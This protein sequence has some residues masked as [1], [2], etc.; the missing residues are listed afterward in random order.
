MYSSF[1]IRP[2]LLFLILTVTLFLDGCAETTHTRD[3]QPAQNEDNSWEDKEKRASLY[4]YIL[5]SRA[6]MIRQGK[7]FLVKDKN[8]EAVGKFKEYFEHLDLVGR[9]GHHE[10]GNDFCEVGIKLSPSSETMADCV[11]AND[12]NNRFFYQMANI[13]MAQAKFKLKKYQE[14]IPFAKAAFS[15]IK[16]TNRSLLRA[17]TA[18]FVLGKSCVMLEKKSCAQNSIDSL[19]DLQVI[20]MK[21]EFEDSEEFTSST[22]DR[23]TKE[24]RRDLENISSVR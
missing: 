2:A 8:I 5:T 13:G 23:F 17:A 21:E 11:L 18:H 19:V 14:A 6:E 9:D 24:L 16:I 15:G 22:L 20:N 1:F 12:I 10:L 3:N 7:D 4:K